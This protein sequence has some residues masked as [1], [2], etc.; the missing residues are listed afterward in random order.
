MFS[1]TPGSGGGLVASAASR[2]VL[3]TSIGAIG[4]ATSG[5]FV[6]LSA[7]SPGTA[8]FFRCV[9]ALPFLVPLALAE[10]GATGGMSSAQRGWA[11]LAGILF[12]ADALLWTQ[13]IY[14]IGIGLSAVLVNTQVVVVPLL[15]VVIDREPLSRRFLVILPVIVAGTLLAGGV[16]ESAVTGSAPVE[17][18][19]YAVL[20][21][22]CYSGF[23]FLLRRGGPDRPL[24]QSYVVIM[25]S[26]A[27]VAIAAGSVWGGF[28]AS[29]GWGPVG[30]LALT[31]ICGQVLG[32]LLVAVGTPRLRVEIG[33]TL[34][35]L[36]PVGALLLGAVVLGEFPSALQI[37]GCVLVL[38]SAYLTTAGN[39]RRAQRTP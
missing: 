8:S 24:V 35:L 17:G 38:G 10:R 36:T 14:E 7:T 22:L 19:V 12:A 3:A 26:A 6:A 5:L 13:A 20:A 33:S 34:L 32:W 11:A 39:G 27:V 37:L 2:P 31:A 21:A 28:D 18:T 16:F 30:W 15:A 25:A 4:V 29:P 23:L 9:L 1:R